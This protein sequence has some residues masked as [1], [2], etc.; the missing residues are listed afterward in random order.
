MYTATSHVEPDWYPLSFDASES[1][2]GDLLLGYDLIP[3]S[4]KDAFPTTVDIRPKSIESKLTMA[5]IGLRDIIPSLDLFPVNKVFCKFDISGDNKYP[6]VTNKHAVLGGS[7]NIFEVITIDLDV[8]IDYEN[9]S[10]VLTVFV[11]DTVFGAVGERLVGV[12]N[13]PLHEFC[14]KIIKSMNA[15][16]KTL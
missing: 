14:E 16:S 9:Y 3:L 13:I 10:P 5:V 11:Y 7:A 4:F 1:S 2:D 6:I 8:P 12:T 15:V